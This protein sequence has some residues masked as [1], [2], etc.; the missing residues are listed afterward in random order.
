MKHIEQ[1]LTILF[2]QSKDDQF[3]KVNLLQNWSEIMGN[4]ASKV[5]IH[6]IYNDSITLG[7]YELCWMQ[8][9]Y[10]LSPVIQKKI[11]AFLGSDK[12]KTIRFRAAQKKEKRKKKKT[13]IKKVEKKELTEHEQASIKKIKDPELAHSL[14]LLLEQCQ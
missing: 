9:L 3:W 5:M 8:E 14:K 7:V 13:V 10:I 12:I 1:A 4:I 6:K 2:Q 11:N